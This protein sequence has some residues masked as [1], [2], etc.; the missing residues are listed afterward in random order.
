MKQYRRFWILML[1]LVLCV[2]LLSACASKKAASPATN[3]ET[4]SAEEWKP[5]KTDIQVASD[6]LYVRKVENL[7]DDFIMGMDASCV[8]A[9]EASG[10]QYYDYDGTQKD[11]YEILRNNGINYIRVR[12]WNDPFNAD[13]KGYGG[14]NCDLANAIAVGK[15][16]TQYGMKLLVNFH[17]SDFWADPAKQM[18]PK[19]WKGMTIEE[20]SEALYAYT[21]DCLQQ[22]VDAGVDVG[23]VQIGNETTGAM[24]GESSS[25]VGGWK[26]ITQLM[27]AGSKAVREVC[28]HALVAVHFTNPEN[29]DSYV[30]YGK[31][32]DYYGV[33][34]DVFASSYYPYWHGTYENLA[35]VLSD[36][37]ETYG[38]KVMVAETSYAFTAQDSDF[39]GNTIG[40]G[41][42][43]V[44]DYPLTMQGQANLVR[45]LVDTLVNRTTDAI[46]VFYWEGTW[47]SVGTESYDTNVALW[48]R[49]GSGWASSYAA[50]Y[51]PEDAGQWYGGCAVDNQAFFT[52]DGKVTEALKVFA[53]MQTGNA[54]ENRVDALEDAEVICDL[55]GTIELPKTVDAVM[56]D[57]S[58]VAVPV[59]WETIDESAIKAGGVAKH[60]IKGKAD[61]QDVRCVLSM[62]EFNYLDNWSFEEGDG[63]WTAT[64]IGSFD[65]LYVEDKVTDSVTGTK[66]YHFWGAAADA[67]EFT[68]EQQ[69][70]DLPAG[71]Y[72]YGISIMGGDG[73]DTDIY[74]YVKINGK[75]VKKQPAAITVY[76]EWHTA[77]IEGIV[78]DA[79]DVVTVGLYVKCAGPNAWGKIDDAM[80]N[81]V[82]ETGEYDEK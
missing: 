33:D 46:G 3:E 24:C 60:T 76:D 38:K 45:D 1:S 28:P 58:R 59:E 69:V 47:I 74:A 44:Q 56:L 17:Y 73:G 8:P 6:S 35:A 70:A 82:S 13:G 4:D 37:A 18:V 64:A 26:K 80:L 23:M 36:I 42:N 16:A 81:S 66:H 11:V 72:K 67:V 77:W 51:D 39:S 32:L 29:A 57:N 10:V 21:K 52:A 12:V 65:Q 62:V 41:G 49:Y 30:S 31:N 25:A 14:G 27:S 61:G 63:G 78:C 15:R 55:N 50:E 54:I 75:I 20:K 5:N 43:F 79:D 34:Y 48:E 68:L 7:P 19:A 2:G 22:L 40:E 9:L 71:T 53:L